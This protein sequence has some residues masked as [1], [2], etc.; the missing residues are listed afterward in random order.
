MSMAAISDMA[1]SFHMRQRST[2]VKTQMLR[3]TAELGSGKISDLGTALGGDFAGLAAIERGLRLGTAYKTAIDEAALQ[4]SAMQTALGTISSQLDTTGPKLFSAVA[5]GS[6]PNLDAAAADAGS[7]LDHLINALNG[8]TAGRSLFSG[9]RPGQPPLISGADM[10][11][12]IAPLLAGATNAQDMITIVEDWFLAPGG[13][14]ETTAYQGGT[15]PASGFTLADGDV[16]TPGLSALTPEI[17]E[18]LVGFAL[19]ALV[20]QGQG[21]G[22]ETSRR[23]LL[24]SAGNKM[25]GSQSGLSAI[26]ADLGTMEARVEA[27]RVRNTASRTVLSVEH[28]RLTGADPFTTAT[29]LEAVQAQL[30]SLFILTARMARLN[31][32]EFLR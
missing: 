13:G 5:S 23:T 20:S 11:T 17:R 22:D 7:K 6:L 26:R 9:D 30:E 1:Q 24:E 19:T 14:F 15:A 10:L 16:V 8:K 2:E 18:A 28:N 29:E 12:E 31:L 3:L 27:A 32:A 21:P 25:L 4:T